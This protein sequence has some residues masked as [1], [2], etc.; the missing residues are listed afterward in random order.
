MAI[1]VEDPSF[2]LIPGLIMV[3]ETDNWGIPGGLLPADPLAPSYLAPSVDLPED[4]LVELRGQVLS[5]T[6]PPNVFA[7]YDDGSFTVAAGCPNGTYTFTVR[8]YADQ[9]EQAPLVTFT[10][11]VGPTGALTVSTSI[12]GFTASLDLTVF[13][14]PLL[15]IGG[16][17]GTFT[18]NVDVSST[19]PGVALLAA[20][21]NFAASVSM[22]STVPAASVAAS[23]EAFG[24]TFDFLGTTPNVSINAALGEH[25]S[26][27]VITG[28]ADAV[29][30][31]AGTLPAFTSSVS[32]KGG[33]PLPEALSLARTYVVNPDVHLDAYRV[34][35]AYALTWE[36][37]PH[38]TLDYTVDWTEWLAEIPND[39][40]L[41][42]SVINTSNIEIL[43][44]EVRGG[45]TAVLISGG[46]P[47]TPAPVKAK[48]ES[49]TIRI[50]TTQGRIDERTIRLVIRNL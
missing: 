7:Y 23:M 22:S 18:A 20:I 31:L 45:K 12:G 38:S 50:E 49:V 17:M 26:T 44:Q 30:T 11:I 27:L 8:V 32:M 40:I 39:S 21:D 29:F 15:T 42:M 16:D 4:A 34:N 1:L 9:V 28:A 35:Y 2:S 5:H 33:P 48:F 14:S 3:R 43:G 25:L 19:V 47:A 36:K 6:F 46:L 41:S 10:V 37:D 24:A 13:P